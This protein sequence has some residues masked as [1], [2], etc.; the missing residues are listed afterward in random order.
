MRI[1]H[2]ERELIDDGFYVVGS[3][4]D[5]N[6]HNDCTCRPIKMSLLRFPSGRPL[7]DNLE[8][9][10]E[11]ADSDMFSDEGLKKLAP[12]FC[13][14]YA[15]IMRGNRSGWQLGAFRVFYGGIQ[16]YYGNPQTHESGFLWVV[17]A[18]EMYL[19]FET[20][21]TKLG[22]TPTYEVRIEESRN[23]RG[24]DTEIEEDLGYIRREITIKLKDPNQKSSIFHIGNQIAHVTEYAGM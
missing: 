13:E 12:D 14:N 5:K 22:F 10:I 16:L 4:R 1:E 7:C 20:P 9:L 15:E 19:K 11:L 21:R 3:D 18:S 17:G 2:Y 6:S 8:E 23:G 24:Y